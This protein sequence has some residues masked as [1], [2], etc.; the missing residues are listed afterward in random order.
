MTTTAVSQKKEAPSLSKGAENGHSNK[1]V[2]KKKAEDL[3]KKLPTDF[4]VQERIS[5]LEHMS[6]LVNKYSSVKDKENQMKR[7]LAEADGSQEYV[8]FLSGHE[9]KLRITNTAIMRKLVQVVQ[10]EMKGFRESVENEILSFS[11]EG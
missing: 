5:H 10:S 4:T 7:Y 11:F 2:V 8:V 6:I 1:S 3:R 9:E